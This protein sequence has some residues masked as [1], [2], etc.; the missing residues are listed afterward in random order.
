MIVLLA[1]V[2][3]VTVGWF[4]GDLMGELLTLALVVQLVIELI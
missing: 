4:F 1:M 2:A 3:I